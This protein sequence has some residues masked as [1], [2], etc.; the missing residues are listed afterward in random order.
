[1]YAVYR[2]P[3][4]ALIAVSGSFGELLGR[5]AGENSKEQRSRE[6]PECGVIRVW[7]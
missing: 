4:D 6:E 3:Y 7:R 2:S 1:M 5:S